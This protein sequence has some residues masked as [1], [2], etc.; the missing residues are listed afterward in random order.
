MVPN[1]VRGLRGAA[2]RLTAR[3]RRRTDSDR[4][5]LPLGLHSEG[6][7][8]RAIA[9]VLRISQNTVADVLAGRDPAER[10]RKAIASGGGTS[11][12]RTASEGGTSTGR[13]AGNSAGEIDRDAVS[14]V[15]STE[16]PDLE[17]AEEIAA[18]KQETSTSN[19]QVAIAMATSR[20]KVDALMKWR[21]SGFK[22]QSPF[23]MD[24]Q[25]TDR[26]ALSL[27]VGGR[28]AVPPFRASI[29]HPSR[30][31]RG[32]FLAPHA[33]L[34]GMVARM[35]RVASTSRKTAEDRRLAALARVA[36]TSTASEATLAAKARALVELV[37]AGDRSPLSR[38]TLKRHLQQ[39]A[40]TEAVSSRGLAAV[41][42]ALDALELLEHPDRARGRG[43]GEWLSPTPD[44]LAPR[45]YWPFGEWHPQEGDPGRWE[46]LMLDD[47]QA[48]RDAWRCRTEGP[49]PWRRKHSL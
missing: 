5:E 8:A 44:K 39:V 12:G 21:E 16:E 23:L 6:L 35:G 11:S 22:A 1:P 7:S 30:V 4:G 49:A 33:R 14:G 42:A 28:G 13:G 17:S 31:A 2:E 27:G 3:H 47:T 43:D 25:A 20:Q 10:E 41:F 37:D 40:E 36:R 34:P 19:R 9:D 38:R 24:E 45:G 48:L 18:Y 32:T 46:E 15:D 26:A 29:G